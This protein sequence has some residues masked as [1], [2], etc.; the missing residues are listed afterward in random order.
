VA[1]SHRYNDSDNAVRLPG[2]GLVN[3]SAQYEINNNLKVQTK[4]ENI[5]DKKHTTVADFNSPGRASYISISYQS[6]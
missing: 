6:T 3:I 5:L 1:Q 2:Y 4:I